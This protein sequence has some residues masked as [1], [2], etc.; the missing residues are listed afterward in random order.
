MLGGGLQLAGNHNKCLMSSRQPPLT[1][2]S[3][4]RPLA[5]HPQAVVNAPCST[6]RSG[7]S[8]Q[9]LRLQRIGHSPLHALH[10]V[11]QQMVFS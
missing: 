11:G 4:I 10:A 3:A 7:E 8:A 1:R 6:S 5:V 9:L 2:S